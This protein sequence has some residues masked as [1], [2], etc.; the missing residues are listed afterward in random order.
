MSHREIT[1]ILIFYEETLVYGIGG[2]IDKVDVY[3]CTGVQIYSCTSKV[4][5]DLNKV[6]LQIYWVFKLRFA[7]LSIKTWPV[8]GDNILYPDC[9]R[10]MLFTLLL[11]SSP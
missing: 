2:H 3:T 6:F 11:F 7:F 8:L 5:S 10:F 9:A 1:A 4:L